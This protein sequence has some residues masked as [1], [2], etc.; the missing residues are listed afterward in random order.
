MRTEFTGLGSTQPLNR[1]EYHG[2]LL[3]DK[4]DRCVWLTTLPPSYANCLE[5]LG[6]S[7]SWRSKGLSR[8]PG[9][10]G[11]QCVCRADSS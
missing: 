6:A 10:E 1:N 2:Y 8:S 3:Q 11:G 5:I 4:G 7:T 9:G